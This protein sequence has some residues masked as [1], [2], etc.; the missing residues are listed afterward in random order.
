MKNFGEKLLEWDTEH[1]ENNSIKKEFTEKE[2]R[3]F[4]AQNPGVNMKEYLELL[5]MKI[6]E[7]K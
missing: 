6:G 3:K 1:R 5:G 4:K 7:T 2:L